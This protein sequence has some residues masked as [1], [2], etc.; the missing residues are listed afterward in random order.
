MKDAS[1]I[2]I[3]ERLAL[4]GKG[5]RAAAASGDLDTFR[6]PNRDGRPGRRKVSRAAMDRWIKSM[7]E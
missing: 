6:A 5:V 4:D 1:R 2:P 7:E 3:A